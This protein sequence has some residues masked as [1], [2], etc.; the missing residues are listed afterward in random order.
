VI[1]KQGGNPR[2]NFNRRPLAI[3][4]SLQNGVLLF[5][6]LK[7]ERMKKLFLIL[8]C[9]ISLISYS[10]ERHNQTFYL[11]GKVIDFENV[12]I[13]PM[14]IDSLFVEKQTD[15]G[16]VYLYTTKQIEYI[17][18]DSVLQS[19]TTLDKEQ[20]NIL[21]II[22]DK[23]IKCESK[24]LIDK[25]F[26]IYVKTNFLDEVEYLDESLKGLIIVNISLKSE[27]QIRIRGDKKAIDNLIYK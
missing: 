3:S 13:N 17:N 18:L 27:K 2:Y 1:L 16:E 26:F 19:H 22:A 9:L 6:N 5:I 20:N 8:F 24:V 21:Y 4:R 15:V 25:S 10:Q 23:V 14:N 7:V 11:N 12:Y